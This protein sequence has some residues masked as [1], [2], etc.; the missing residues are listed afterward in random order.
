MANNSYGNVTKEGPYGNAS[1]HVK[2]AY[3]VGVYPLEYVSHEDAVKAIKK[4]DKTLRYSY[5]IYQVNV[6][7]GVNAGYETG[8][9]HG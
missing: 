6:T 9:I 8:R 2:V 1:S 5:Y 3:I 7:G 4:L